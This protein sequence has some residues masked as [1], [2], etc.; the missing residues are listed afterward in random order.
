MYSSCSFFALADSPRFE[1][2]EEE[3]RVG[4]LHLGQQREVV[5]R[6]DALD[7]GS[8]QQRVADLLLRGIGALRRSAVGKLQ[9]K[10]HIALIFSGNESAG[11]AAAQIDRDQ[12]SEMRPSMAKADL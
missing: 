4:A 5:D 6:D 9:A 12:P 10:E 8:L 2:Y 1:V 7:A 11:K 3:S